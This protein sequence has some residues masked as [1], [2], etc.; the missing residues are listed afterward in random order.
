MHK[1]VG[2]MTSYQAAPWPHWQGS[3]HRLL[4]YFKKGVDT[5]IQFLIAITVLFELDYL[6][7]RNIRPGN[8][9]VESTPNKHFSA[10]KDIYF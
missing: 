8:N 5:K 7:S 10:E 6:N 3:N 9:L 1:R 4:G 2:S